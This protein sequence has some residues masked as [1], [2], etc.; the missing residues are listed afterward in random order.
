[1]LKPIPDVIGIG[2]RIFIPGKG[3][4]RAHQ[5]FIERLQERLRNRMVRHPETNGLA[6]RLHQPFGHIPG[7]LQ[8]ERVGTGGGITHQSIGGIVYPGISAQLGQVAAHQREIMVISQSTDPPD[9]LHGLL[10]SQ[11]TAQR[12]S[13]IRGIHHDTATLNDVNRLLYQTSLWC[14][15]VDGKKLAHSCSQTPMP[16]GI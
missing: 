2:H 7:R 16:S 13:R 9:A 8:Y 12:I 3:Q 11:L 14:L 15:G 5:G 4:G 10:V 6:L 1:M